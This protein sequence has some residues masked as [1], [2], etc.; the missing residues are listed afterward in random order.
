MGQKTAPAVEVRHGRRR[1]Q[2]YDVQLAAAGGPK[3]DRR[4]RG[5]GV[6]NI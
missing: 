3:S 1:V 4:R 5:N 2:T 6:R